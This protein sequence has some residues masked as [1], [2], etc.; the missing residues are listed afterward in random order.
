M[1]LNK[2]SETATKITFTHEK[3]AGA[4][5]YLYYSDGKRVSRTFNPDDLEVTFGKVDSGKYAVEA[6]GFTSLAKAEW[7]KPTPPTP[8]KF[9]ELLPA[10]LAPSKGDGGTIYISPTGSDSG[11]G[12]INRP[13]KTPHKAFSVVNLTGGLILARGGT[14]N[15][16]GTGEAGIQQV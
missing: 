9:G 6:V 14:Y 1:E 5:G 8:S 15:L 10:R 2:K 16:S 3:P 7:P 11:D 12:S 4:E 13:F